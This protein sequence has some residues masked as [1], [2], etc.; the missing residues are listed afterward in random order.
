MRRLSDRNLYLLE[1]GFYSRSIAQRDTC[2][3]AYSSPAGSSPLARISCNET[4][5]SHNVFELVRS[6]KTLALILRYVS[7][8]LSTRGERVCDAHFLLQ[9]GGSWARNDKE[10]IQS[11]GVRI[12]NARPLR[13]MRFGKSFRICLEKSSACDAPTQATCNHNFYF[14]THN[15]HTPHLFRSLAFEL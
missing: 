1:R 7:L 6:A 9:N 12:G 13:T 15:K 8:P 14:S 4:D 2:A 3:T 5:N 11:T 10:G